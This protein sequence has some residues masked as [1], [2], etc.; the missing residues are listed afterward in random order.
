MD[1]LF[2]VTELAKKLEDEEAH[3]AEEKQA[4]VDVKETK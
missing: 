3:H 4:E 1:D 2:G